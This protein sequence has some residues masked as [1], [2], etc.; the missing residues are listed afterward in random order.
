[1]S[2][3]SGSIVYEAR[4]GYETQR[5]SVVFYPGF[6]MQTG[7]MDKNV[8]T[9]RYSNDLHEL[10]LKDGTSTIIGKQREKQRCT[11]NAIIKTRHLKAHK[12]EE[13][14]CADPDNDEVFNRSIVANLSQRISRL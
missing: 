9:W 3:Q 4:F 14:C 13:S 10:N 7:D 2:T 11:S 8:A 12:A 1:M 6:L 5:E